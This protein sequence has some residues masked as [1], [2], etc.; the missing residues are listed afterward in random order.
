MRAEGVAE[1]VGVAAVFGQVGIGSV[2]AHDPRDVAANLPDRCGDAAVACAGVA[3]PLL[4][5]LPVKVPLASCEQ[6]DLRAKATR[7]ERRWR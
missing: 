1:H 3:A 7:G 6:Q 4:N 5:E 2:T